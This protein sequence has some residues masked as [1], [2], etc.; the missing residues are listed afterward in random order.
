MG[1]NIDMIGVIILNYNSFADTIKLVEDLQLQTVAKD[2]QIIIVDNASPNDSYT[3]LKPLEKQYANVVVLQTGAN[4]GYAKGN[5]FGLNYLDE[6]IKPA[7]V[8]ILN[9]DIILPN[10]CFS[11]LIAKYENLDK[12]AIIAPKQLDINNKEMA[13][14]PINSFLDD[15]LNLFFIFRIFQ[16]RKALKYKDNSGQ[17]AMKVEMIPG[18]F[19]FASFEKFK[20]MGFFY[21]N[22][23]LFVEE[24]FIGVKAKQMNLYNYILLDETYIH[25]HSKTINTAFSQ[26][27]KYRLLY[28]GWLEFT[29]RCRTNGELKV[30]ILKPLMKLSLLEM[31]ILYGVRNTLKKI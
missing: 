16:K 29:K 23:F 18:S 22:T 1:K 26:V 8:A 10:D 21:P 20:N 13:P 17:R 9:N 25:A 19:M 3:Q 6:H 5:N 15:F 7:F 27:G 24:R 28:D 11:K 31:R 4:L 30:A 14:Y 12:P 2:L